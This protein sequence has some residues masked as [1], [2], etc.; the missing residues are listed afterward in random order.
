MSGHRISISDIAAGRFWQIA[1]LTAAGAIGLAS[2]AEAAR[3]YWSDYD[4][5]FS[6]GRPAEPP[7][8]QQRVRPR[9][10]KK[11]EAPKESVKPQGPLIIAISIEKQSLKVYDANGFFAEIAD[12]HGH[13]GPSDADG[14][15]QHHSKA[16]A[17]P[18]QHL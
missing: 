16:Q 1:V 11:V 6:Q 2:P 17:A 4:Y 9:Q 15:L 7:P 3:Y 5:G 13:E 8:R 12:L 18:F 14:R 10:A